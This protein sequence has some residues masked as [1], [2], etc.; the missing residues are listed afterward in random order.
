MS[1]LVSKAVKKLKTWEVE[2][3]VS[4]V[5]EKRDNMAPQATE[6]SGVDKKKV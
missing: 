6:K 2:Q 5:C 4:D 1:F 3:H